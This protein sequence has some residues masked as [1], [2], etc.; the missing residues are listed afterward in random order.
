MRGKELVPRL[1]ASSFPEIICPSVF[2][3]S[4]NSDVDMIATPLFVSGALPSVLL[5][6]IPTCVFSHKLLLLLL[7]YLMA[8][9]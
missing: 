5:L 4:W 3:S 8:F 1:A 6:H 7:I 9:A 2:F